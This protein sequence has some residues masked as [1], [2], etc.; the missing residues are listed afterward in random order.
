MLE[1]YTQV[2]E[3][4]RKSPFTLTRRACAESRDPPQKYLTVFLTSST[5]SDDDRDIESDVSTFPP[6]YCPFCHAIHL[7]DTLIAQIMKP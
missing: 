1:V 4:K 3:N 6:I 2:P 7:N 5:M